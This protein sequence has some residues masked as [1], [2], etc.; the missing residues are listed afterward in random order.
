M[1]FEKTLN[2]L[3]EKLIQNVLPE[4]GYYSIGLVLRFS[5]DEQ[6]NQFCKDI[7]SDMSEYTGYRIIK[8]QFNSSVKDNVIDCL[9]KTSNLIDKYEVEIMDVVFNPTNEISNEDKELVIL[10]V[11]GVY[12]AEFPI[13]NSRRQKPINLITKG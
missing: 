13:E 1:Y 2:L 12:G 4:G 11:V 3:E 9:H 5:T 10:E 8:L 6:F 7:V